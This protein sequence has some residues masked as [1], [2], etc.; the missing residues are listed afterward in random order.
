LG[1]LISSNYAWGEEATGD[2]QRLD[3]IATQFSNKLSKN[4]GT[5]HLLMA[6]NQ[7]TE[8]ILKSM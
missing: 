4:A 7:T 2:N 5:L 3:L 6:K 8:A 1:N